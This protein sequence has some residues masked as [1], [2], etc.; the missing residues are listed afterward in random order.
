MKIVITE[1]CTAYNTTVDGVSVCDIDKKQMEEIYDKMLIKLK[2]GLIDNTISFNSLINNFQ[3]DDY[4][5]DEHSC[6]Q[7]G[8]SISTT[9]WE[10]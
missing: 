8:D 2:E 7:C 9:T 1:G 4:K 3:Y 10:I 6:E 5:V